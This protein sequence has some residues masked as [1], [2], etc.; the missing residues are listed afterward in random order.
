[1]APLPPTSSRIEMDPLRNSPKKP[2]ASPES[3][4]SGPLLPKAAEANPDSRS[5]REIVLLAVT[6]MAPAVVTE[7]VWALA[8]EHPPVLPHRICILTTSAGKRCAEE[9]L[10]SPSP[11]FGGC[12]V[13]EILRQTLL[14]DREDRSPR[15]IFDE[16]RLLGHPDPREGRR[17]PLEDIRRASENEAL[18]D[19]L[20]EEVRRISE[21]PDTALI[22]SI[23]GGRKTMSALL[24]ACVS[25]LGRPQDRVT[26]VLVNEPFDD[27]R[28]SPRFYFPTC[29]ASR[30][31]FPIPGKRALRTISSDAAQ[32]E[33]ADIPFVPLRLLFP[34]QIGSFPGHFTTLVESCSE[35]LSSLARK[36]RVSLQEDRPFL[37]VDGRSV[38]LSPREY[39]LYAFLLDRLRN[40]SPPFSAQKDAVT[41]LIEFL[42]RLSQTHP[43]ES[44]QRQAAGAWDDPNDD[45]LRKLLSSVRKKLRAAGFAAELDR[46]LPRRGSFGI[47]AIPG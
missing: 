19:A 13:W 37:I 35:R 38:S 21:N 39:L 26:H 8:H 25:L 5:S 3:D 12:S 33:L 10:F 24:Y 45:D 2:S 15:L 29:P 40:G 32:I 44:F 11:A 18:A 1:M 41:T 42:S 16:I 6:G 9:E 31:S 22:A 14:R 46:L 4:F 7:T 20:L 17:R 43:V 23:A 34:K 47:D 36:P 30:H 27:P 28:L